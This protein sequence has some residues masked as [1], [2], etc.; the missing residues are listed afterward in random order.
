[1]GNRD[2]AC[3]RRP[4]RARSFRPSKRNSNA[5]S[6]PTRPFGVSGFTSAVGLDYRT[7]NGFAEPRSWKDL[8]D[9]KLAGVRGGYEAVWLSPSNRK[10]KL[11]ANYDGK[12]Y[13]TE[14]KVAQLIQVDWKWYNARK[15]DIDARVT[16]ILR[17]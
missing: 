8:A 15:D 1:M 12:L 17:G 16:R 11:D 10:V 7:D 14:A 2:R 5:R 13:N 3:R 4:R 9:P 6:K